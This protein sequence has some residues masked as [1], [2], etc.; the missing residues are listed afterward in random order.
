MSRYSP[1][2]L[3]EYGTPI[4][5]YVA[6][7]LEMYRDRRRQAN[8]ER[9]RAE[10]RRMAMEDRDRQARRD[11]ADLAL[12]GYRTGPQPKEPTVF[13]P[14]IGAPGTAL[15]GELT[16]PPAARPQPPVSPLAEDSFA[17]NLGANL[18]GTSPRRPDPDPLWRAPA[19]T[20]MAPTGP[21]AGG[22]DT[23]G[24][25]AGHASRTEPT[26]DTTPG[27]FNP[28]T[29]TFGG[30][31]RP[32]PQR[33]P[34]REV[35]MS[36]R[37]RYVNAD[38]PAGEG[39]VDTW[40]TKEAR[41]W[42]RQVAGAQLAAELRQQEEAG[43][44][45]R[46]VAA[47]IA[48]GMTPEKARAAVE[49]PALADN[50]LFPREPSESWSIQTDDQGYLYRVN[51]RTGATHP[52]TGPDKKPFR[53][54]NPEAREDQRDEDRRQAAVWRRVQELVRP[55][56]DPGTGLTKPGMP[57]D[58][59]HEQATR[60]VDTV[61]GGGRQ[62]PTIVQ[63]AVERIQKGEGTLD[64]LRASGVSAVTIAEVERQLG[65]NRSPSAPPQR[66]R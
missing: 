34:G 33:G 47:Y 39:Y 43:E 41:A 56:R 59:A 7:A 58:K 19:T 35:R 16:R 18:R 8:M 52:V 32:A 29:G 64:E 60:E 5:A 11:A 23:M 62:T 26:S 44:R 13:F 46:K 49:N 40:G 3:P 27:A 17:R 2:V 53:R 6:D 28:A 65:Q 37:D 30:P 31:P 54:A 14:E 51:P 36:P 55:A 4:T 63:R 25:M 21:T 1:Q 12:S 20:R 38:S 57:L 48:A 24:G 66:D 61:L 45:D 15:A 50:I 9:E 10:D 22:P 42:E